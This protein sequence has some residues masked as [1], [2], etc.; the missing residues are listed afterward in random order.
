M[1][2]NFSGAVYERQI[3]RASELYACCSIV[4]REENTENLTAKIE[5]RPCKGIYI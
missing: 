5:K 3:A 4:Y 1:G 2:H